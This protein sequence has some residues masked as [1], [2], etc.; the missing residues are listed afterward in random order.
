MSASAWPGLLRDRDFGR[1]F[2]ATA[3]GQFGDRVVFLVLPLISI[4]VLDADEFQVGLLAALTSAGSL[5]VGLPAGAWVDRVRKRSVLIVADLARA[6]ALASVP[7]AWWADCLTFWWLCTVALLHGTLTVFFDVAYLSYVPHLVGRDNVVEGNAKLSAMRSATSI[8]GPAAAGPL[9]GLLGAPATLVASSTGMA[10]SGLVVTTIR[11]HE[12]KPSPN[13]Q[14]GLWRE[15]KKGLKFVLRHPALRAITLGDAVFN[16]FLAMYQA[17]LLVFL[18]RE[19]DL[20]SFGI[21]LILSGMGCGALLGALLATTV[22][23]R[24]GQG[25]AIWLAP[26][27]TCPLTALLPL[28][29][30]GWSVGVAATGL[31]ALSLGGVIRVVAQSSYQQAV[32]PDGLLGRMNATARFISW[33]GIPLGAFLGGT[34]G[35]A[36]GAS[37]TLWA[38][39]AGMTLSALPTLLSPLRSTH[40]AD[41]R[42]PAALDPPDPATHAP[43]TKA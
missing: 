43:D 28:A 23:K 11:K 1:L 38:G 31:V 34:L 32:T 14:P 36:L 5:L 7:A 35:S 3:L 40:T 37:A 29:R 9:I 16:L 2:A 27:V 10:L 39:A 19:T 15:I 24:V 26:L 4:A 22:T 21:G 12:P 17:M 13:R 20:Q 42:H 8:S 33:A 30:P 41:R 25:P 6:L 18:E